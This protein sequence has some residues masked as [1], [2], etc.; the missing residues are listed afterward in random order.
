MFA[1]SA[2]LLSASLLAAGDVVFSDT[3]DLSL[4]GCPDSSIRASRGDIRYPTT[5][6]SLRQD[7]DLTL[8]ENIWG[9]SNNNDSVVPWPG[10]NGSSPALLHFGKNQFF[11]ARFHVPPGITTTSSG[12]YGYSTYFSGPLM[13][14]A[15]STTCGDFLPTNTACVSTRGAGESFGK[16]RISPNVQNCP[17][18]PDTDYFV[19]GRLVNAQP[20]DCIGQ[21]ECSI[22]LN[23]TFN[24]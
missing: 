19:N 18:T 5:G 20:Q 4:D 8:F 14:I 1:T 15:I 7:V 3:F 6:Y 10:R 16:W 12:F 24:N 21:P 22:G 9:H 17:L 23:S 2:L 13:E 11:A